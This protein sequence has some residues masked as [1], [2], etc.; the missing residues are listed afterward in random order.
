MRYHD[1]IFVFV[2]C[3]QVFCAGKV[4]FVFLYINK[5]IL[6]EMGGFVHDRL[7]IFMPSNLTP[8]HIY[9]LNG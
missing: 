7:S 4:N 2:R 8:T 3:I 9:I 6:L 1:E 5:L